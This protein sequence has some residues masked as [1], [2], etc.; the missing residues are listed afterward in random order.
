MKKQPIPY[1]ELDPAIVPLVRALNELET[2]QTV[3]S[4]SGRHPGA[5]A[6]DHWRVWF[7][8]EENNLGWIDLEILQLCLYRYNQGFPFDW[9]VLLVPDGQGQL[10]F[11]LAGKQHIEPAAFAQTILEWKESYY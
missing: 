4:C 7:L 2:I 1:D 10:C 11:C 6:P 5:F 3:E 8:I 9:D